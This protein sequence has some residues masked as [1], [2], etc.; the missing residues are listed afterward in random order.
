MKAKHTYTSAGVYKAEVKVKFV[1]N[2]V[3]CYAFTTTVEALA[4]PQIQLSISPKKITLPKTQCTATITTANAGSVVIDWADGFSDN[5]NLNLNFFTQTHNYA[6]SGHYLVKATAYN[7]NT[8]YTKTSAS[9][10]HADTFT[11]FI[12]NAFTPNKDVTNEAFKPVVS[13][14]KSYELIIFNRWGEEI[15]KA[16]YIAGKNQEQVWTGEGCE[17]DTYLYILTAIDGDNIHY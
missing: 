2:P 15:Y 7:T 8:C 13:F 10:Y 12:P 11:C 6:D 5:F 14:C 17:M 3:A 4:I 16:N 1:N 9:V